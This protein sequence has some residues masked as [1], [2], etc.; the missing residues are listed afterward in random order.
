V[1]GDS[2]SPFDAGI[3]IL[4][5]KTPPNVDNN[6]PSGN[7]ILGNTVTGRYTGIFVIKS[8][9]NLIS[10]NSITFGVATAG[11][12][13]MV[14]RD[15]DRNSV[16]GNTIR[17]DSIY[18]NPTGVG[19]LLPQ[20]QYNGLSSQSRGIQSAAYGGAVFNFVYDGQLTQVPVTPAM[21]KSPVTGTFLGTC[22]VSGGPTLGTCSGNSAAKCADDGD[23]GLSVDSFTSDFTLE[24]NVFDHNVI[25]Y[26]SQN[27][28]GYHS[29]IQMMGIIDSGGAADG[30][31]T[32]N[33]IE[34]C[35]LALNE[36][37]TGENNLSVA[38][39]CSLN[40]GRWC[41]S[42]SDCLLP[43][44]DT[45]SQGTCQGA[46][47]Y[48][49]N[50]QSGSNIDG[51][52]IV[53]EN[54]QL[55]NNDM[56]IL[57][58]GG[59]INTSLIGN[60]ISL[61]HVGILL[62]SKA[63]ESTVVANNKVHDNRFG[64]NLKQVTTQLNDIPNAY[65]AVVTLNDFTNNS[66]I[67]I[68]VASCSNFPGTGAG[69]GLYCL[70]ATDCDN[71]CQ[72]SS[73]T[74]QQ[75]GKPCSTNHDCAGASGPASNGTCN[76]PVGKTKGSCS[77]DAARTCAKN[78]DCAVSCNSSFSFSAELSDQVRGNYWGLTCDQG[79]FVPSLSP[80]AAITDSH[81]FGVPVADLLANALPVPCR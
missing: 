60:D 68:T 36:G 59:A 74:C 33:T 23:C 14:L 54:N 58:A 6:S 80:L 78:S 30:Q 11:R 19:P 77:T 8:D 69:A 20:A 71:S 81:P 16:T 7:K 76:I 37:N 75:T 51:K 5:S 43:G 73:G 72:S 79:G 66:R 41:G 29:S 61:S 21:I 24:G 53:F 40:P 67:P 31:V 22:S 25:D 32:N 56:G 70:D 9:E 1:I 10:E 4:N 49:V 63:L 15:S 27:R 26:G 13:I 62:W 2:E 28:I 42:D 35:T 64:L 55:I 48:T 45:A 12:G 47:T 50:G 39:T 52:N 18:L 44:F 65:G 34:N 46:R 57:L 17:A 3:F 38:G